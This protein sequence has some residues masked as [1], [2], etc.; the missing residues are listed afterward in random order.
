MCQTTF[1]CCHCVVQYQDPVVDRGPRQERV[2]STAS[3]SS[4]AS[5]VDGNSVYNH[6]SEYSKE[7]VHKRAN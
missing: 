6:S 4:F 7:G 3:A 5:S 1:T 2:S